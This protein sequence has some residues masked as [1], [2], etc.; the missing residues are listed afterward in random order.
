MTQSQKFVS[1]ILFHL[2][3]HDINN[4]E[5][6]SILHHQYYHRQI[7]NDDSITDFP[8]STVMSY[9][10]YILSVLLLHNQQFCQYLK[11]Y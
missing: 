10:Q 4:K 11:Y 7:S 2:S 5:P 8:I 1:S 9:Y 6:L 3:L